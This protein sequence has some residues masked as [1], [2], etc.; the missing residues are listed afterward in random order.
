MKNS[1][2]GFVVPLLLVIIAVLVIG[3]G[4]YVYE[5][6]KTEAPAVVDT[7]TQPVN[8]Q[9][10]NTQTP[11]VTAQQNTAINPSNNQSVFV[12]TKRLFFQKKSSR[13]MRAKKL[14]L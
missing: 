3:G 6:K 2:K 9:Q 14:L 10:T 5:N 4:V 12:G 8:Q 1:Q 13:L 7:G 11:P